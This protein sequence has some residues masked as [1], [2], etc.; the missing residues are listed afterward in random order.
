M[1]FYREELHFG[2]KVP[3]RIVIALASPRICH[4]HLVG[5]GIGVNLESIFYIEVNYL[6]S[7]IIAPA[8][9]WYALAR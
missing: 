9:R 7:P 6:T 1:I 5:N 2:V 8:G 3:N 4:S